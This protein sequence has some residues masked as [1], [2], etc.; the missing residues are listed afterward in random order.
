MLKEQD[1]VAKELKIN[2]EIVKLM[3]QDVGDA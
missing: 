2:P 3:T 1:D